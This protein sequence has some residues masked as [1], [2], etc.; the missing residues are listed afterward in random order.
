M[1]NSAVWLFVIIR[2]ICLPFVL[3]QVASGAITCASEAAVEPEEEATTPKSVSLD[4]SPRLAQSQL[5]AI[6]KAAASTRTYALENLGDFR[7]VGRGGGEHRGGGRT[8][9]DATGMYF[10][11]ESRRDASTL[12]EVGGCARTAVVAHLY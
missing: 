10:G 6:E 4:S 7:M 3:P 1:P 12:P 8:T 11:G 5:L 9:M 2:L